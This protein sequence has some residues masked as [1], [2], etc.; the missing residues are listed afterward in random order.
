M[1]PPQTPIRA[2]GPSGSPCT[3]ISPRRAEDEGASAAIGGGSRTAPAADLCGAARLR[4]IPAPHAARRGGTT[5]ICRAPAVVTNFREIYNDHIGRAH[6]GLRPRL[7]ARTAQYRP[8]SSTAVAPG[9]ARHRVVHFPRP[10]RLSWAWG[11]IGAEAARSPPASGMRV[12][13][14][15]RAGEIRRLMAELHGAGPRFPLQRAYFVISPCRYASTGLMH[16]RA[17]SG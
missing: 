16:R 9:A 17:F 12:I 4:W 13:G 7:R 2:I 11:G 1:L 15:T 6:H 14:M 3:P 5:R 8:S 10:R